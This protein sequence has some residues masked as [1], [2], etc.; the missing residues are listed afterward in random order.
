MQPPDDRVPDAL[1]R[2]FEELSDAGKRNILIQMIREVRQSYPTMS[3]DWEIS[4]WILLGSYSKV[5]R[6]ILNGPIGYN[7]L[8]HIRDWMQSEGRVAPVRFDFNRAP[9]LRDGFRASGVT[10]TTYSKIQAVS[11]T[12]LPPEQ[13]KYHPIP[14]ETGSFLVA[15]A[16]NTRIPRESV[17]ELRLQDGFGQVIRFNLIDDGAV[18]GLA[19]R[20]PERYIDTVCSSINDCFPGAKRIM[21][22]EPGRARRE[23]DKWLVTDKASIRYE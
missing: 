10:A 11:Q 5:F 4:E 2:K 1:E 12:P 16:K 23:N 22:L 14:T 17:Y 20:S 19:I 13:V 15:Y 9:P 3:C 21:T 18:H 7:T 8:M 6:K